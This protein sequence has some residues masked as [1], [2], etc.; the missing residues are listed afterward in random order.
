V[1]L[2]LNLKMKQIPLKLLICLLF[3]IGATGQ[4]N[5]GSMYGQGYG[6]QFGTGQRG[7]SGVSGF[8]QSTFGQNSFGQQQQPAQ[9]AVSQQPI[10][11][12]DF[13]SFARTAAVP[14]QASSSGSGSYGGSSYGNSNS[15]GGS[16]AEPSYGPPYG[17]QSTGEYTN[18]YP[19]KLDLSR[20]GPP[21]ADNPCTAYG[22][23]YY[24]LP[25]Y[26]NCYIQCVFER[27]IVK[28]CPGDLVW[29]ARINVC[30]WPTVA[31]AASPGYGATPYGNNGNTYSSSSYGNS[32][33]TYASPSYVPA[34]S[35]YG[36]SSSYPY[37]RKKRSTI[38]RKKLVHGGRDHGGARIIF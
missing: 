22:P 23:Q 30:D 10:S 7:L 3:T 18:Y 33:S 19:E 8:G 16:Y 6:Q 9:T 37:G 21:S 38:E 34:N 17:I 2:P 11:T 1:E 31:A 12:Q 20:C 4:Y 5:T 32:R 15:Y 25:G 24:P 36:G 29:N 13:Q 14:Q 26:P 35:N 27:P 28:P